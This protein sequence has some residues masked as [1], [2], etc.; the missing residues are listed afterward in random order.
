MVSAGLLEALPGNPRGCLFVT[1]YVSAKQPRPHQRALLFGGDEHRPCGL[2][3]RD[4]KGRACK[5]G[6]GRASEASV[7]ESLRPRASKASLFTPASATRA[8]Q[9]WP[10]SIEARPQ[11][12]RRPA[13]N[14][15]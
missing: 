6:R 12:K 15:R 1:D 5:P 4:S 11:A 13:P 3:G 10:A 2:C 8:K 14:P 9:A 7:T